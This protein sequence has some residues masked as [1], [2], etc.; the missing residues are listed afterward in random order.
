MYRVTFYPTK[1]FAHAQ[2]V[3]AGALA[4]REQGLAELDVHSEPVAPLGAHPDNLLWMDVAHRGHTS[5]L[6]FD[7]KDGAGIDPKH[8][9][10]ADLYF[11][12]TLLSSAG[13]TSPRVR[14][15]GLNYQCYHTDLAAHRQL[16]MQ[17][18][19]RP[20]M[21]RYVRQIRDRI[22]MARPPASLVLKADEFESRASDACQ[23]T[24]IYFTRLWPVEGVSSEVADQR[25]RINTQRVA[26]VH[27]LSQAFGARFVGGL[28]D[29]PE[30]RAQAPSLIARLSTRKASYV[31]RMKDSL[32][33]VASTGLHESIGWKFA[34][35][36]AAARCVVS[37]PVRYELGDPV[38]A[39]QHYLA[40]RNIDECLSA[41]DR[42]LSRPE[43][44]YAMRRANER[45]YAQSLRPDV[46]LLRCFQQV[47]AQA[48]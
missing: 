10:N 19:R 38:R 3:L 1:Q 12:R 9:A 8:L 48:A 4:L 15:F 5:R 44:A 31:E 20:R 29:T 37:E 43:V 46:A 16:D 11:K 27:G 24:V 33:G 42:L 35:Y 28:E 39:D 45:Y 34:E 6:C 22:T 7:L 17:V 25:R 14:P 26:L 32:V 40:Y 23:N 18:F 21:A 30:A 2:Q 47:M 41:C 13:V 36:I